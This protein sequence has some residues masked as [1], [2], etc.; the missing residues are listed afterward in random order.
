MTD[1][2]SNERDG[3]DG[4]SGVEQE[5]ADATKE[6]AGDSPA[7]PA[8]SDRNAEAPGDAPDM[9][10]RQR[11]PWLALAAI[12][13]L[14]GLSGWLGVTVHQSNARLQEQAAQ[15][16]ALKQELTAGGADLQKQIDGLIAATER[17]FAEMRQSEGARS[18]Q[19][20]D[21]A[22]RLAAQGKRLR[23]M[24]TT[25]REDWLLAEAE[26]LLKLAN[27]RVRIERSADGAEAL[28]EAADAILRDLDDPDLH[29]L[30]RAIAEDLAALR[31]MNKID[32]EG[33]YLSLVALTRQI[34]NLP[35]RANLGHDSKSALLTMDLEEAPPRS[36]WQRFTDSLLGFFSALKSYVRVHKHGD[37]PKVVAPADALYLQQNLRLILERAQLALLREQEDIYRQSIAQAL[38]WA[39][40]YYPQTL[41]LMKFQETLHSLQN[42]TVVQKFPDISQSLN[43]LHEHIK[44]L[45][46]LTPAP[47]ARPDTEAD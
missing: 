8:A 3:E 24:S 18:T 10:S 11:I 16:L 19:I 15:M 13:L 40:K 27:Q 9:A 23:A 2:N 37:R 41:P 47:T 33:I 1:E 39:E 25:S 36:A 12:M 45:H 20:S 32:V 35:L 21:L 30:R 34:E 44:T 4:G 7:A 29:S 42:K 26:Y 43:L 38:S 6:P 31:L 28:L 14:L 22:N 5:T 17:S 46:L